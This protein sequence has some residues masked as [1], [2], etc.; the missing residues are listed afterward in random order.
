[1][2]TCLTGAT[3]PVLVFLVVVVVFRLLVA[4]DFFF[5][6]V[7]VALW[8]ALAAFT[9]GTATFLLE[10]ASSSDAVAVNAAMISGADVGC[11]KSFGHLVVVSAD[12]CRSRTCRCTA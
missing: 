10:L 7:V 2:S 1:M 9:P 6:V 11:D 5:V 3:M 4:V 8:S 12:V